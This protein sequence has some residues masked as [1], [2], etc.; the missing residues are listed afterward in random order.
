MA[1]LVRLLKNVRPSPALDL[2]GHA[3]EVIRTAHGLRSASGRFVPGEEL[4]DPAGRSEGFF[5]ETARSIAKMCDELADRLFRPRPGSLGAS[6]TQ[7]EPPVGGI[8]W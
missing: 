5:D 8:S 4:S 7:A 2:E 3:R 6:S 1:E